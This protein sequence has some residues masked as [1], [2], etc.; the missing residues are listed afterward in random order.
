MTCIVGFI[1]NK[2]KKV[3]IGGDSAA[4]TSGGSYDITIRKDPKVFKNGDFII[5][6]TTSFRMIQLLRFSFK[7]P[8]INV[9]DIYRY[10]CT[11]FINEVRNCFKNGGFEGGGDFIVGYKD[12]MFTVYDDFQVAEDLLGV[13]SVGC[14]SPYALGA[15]YSLIKS[16]KQPQDKVKFALETASLF[17]AGV[18]KPFIFETT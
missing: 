9:D 3:I 13:S 7:P 2:N 15:I 12:R 8:E 6:C 16:N 18:E 10:M 1:D 17:S 11:D 5:G 4:V 14:G